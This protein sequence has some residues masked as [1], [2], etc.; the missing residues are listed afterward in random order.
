M[1]AKSTKA[2][3]VL[4]ILVVKLE[5]CEWHKSCG[6]VPHAIVHLAHTVN[7][8]LFGCVLPSARRSL[9]SMGRS[10]GRGAGGGGWSLGRLGPVGRVSAGGAGT[11]LDVSEGEMKHLRNATLQ[12]EDL[13]SFAVSIQDVGNVSIRGLDE[14]ERIGLH[15]PSHVNLSLPLVHVRIIN[16]HLE[17][18]L[19]ISGIAELVKMELEVDGHSCAA[20]H[21]LRL[22]VR[23][24]LCIRGLVLF[25]D[26]HLHLSAKQGCVRV[27][28]STC[29]LDRRSSG[30]SRHLLASSPGSLDVHDALVETFAHLET[31]VSS[32]QVGW[33]LVHLSH[34]VRKQRSVTNALLV[35]LLELLILALLPQLGLEEGADQSL[36]GQSH[37]SSRC[38]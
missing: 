17:D 3:L 33:P 4:E 30:D 20:L 25:F 10:L 28:A 8:E 34:D 36:V 37:E 19:A 16:E 18:V 2:L 21:L 22:L 1:R 38:D 35:L 24:F 29:G 7:I 13:Q 26:A 14:K 12:V 23:N 27:V 5:V 11:V 32:G 9:G 31:N 15:I 6:T